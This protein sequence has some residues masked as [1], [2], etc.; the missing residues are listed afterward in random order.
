M[1]TW[2]SASWKNSALI[3]PSKTA[4]TACG[5][6]TSLIMANFAGDRPSRPQL[7]LAVAAGVLRSS[8]LPVDLLDYPDE[9]LARV[10]FVVASVHSQFRMERAK[11]TACIIAAVS[12][13]ITAI[14][15]H[16]IGRPLLRRPTYEL[17]ME[18]NLR[19][20]T[21]VPGCR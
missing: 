4:G 19:A 21:R 8:E 9:I 20:C 13:S 2:N 7:R 15:G 18:P 1:P 12:Q 16:P 10:D 6:A 3:P 5:S 17:D 14:L 11:Q